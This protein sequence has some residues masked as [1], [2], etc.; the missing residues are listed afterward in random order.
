MAEL[1]AERFDDAGEQAIRAG[2][3]ALA[4]VTLPAE[5]IWANGSRIAGSQ[6][7]FPLGQQAPLEAGRNGIPDWIGGEALQALCAPAALHLDP[8]WRQIHLHRRDSPGIDK[9]CM[10]WN[11][12][13]WRKR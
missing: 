1:H 5:K 13:L 3:T 6:F 12:S 4:K 11:G 2:K 8:A 7:I 9:A 10:R